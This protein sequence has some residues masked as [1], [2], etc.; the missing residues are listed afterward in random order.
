MRFQRIL[1]TLSLILFVGLLLMAS[2]P[3]VSWIPV[4][5]FLRLDP[6][7]AF[8]SMLGAKAL[9]AGFLLAGLLLVAGL[10]LGRIF[11]GHICPMGTC[12]D[13]ADRVLLGL[14]KAYS[15]PGKPKIAAWSVPIKYCILIAL[16]LAAFLGV[17]LLFWFAPI[18]LIT[19]FFGLVLFP[20]TGKLAGLALNEI[21]PAAQALDW[22]ALYYLTFSS[23]RYA[24]QLFLVVFFL[25]IFLTAYIAPR[26]WCRSLC[27][28]G[29]IFALFSRRPLIR[30]RVCDDC[31]QCGLCVKQCPMSAIADEPAVTRF[32]ECTVCLRCRE[33]CPVDAIS[34]AFSEPDAPRRPELSEH[35]EPTLPSR[36]ALLWSAA[37]G[38]TSA[39]LALTEPRSPFHQGKTGDLSAPYLIRPPGALPEPDF[40]S[41]CLRCG[42][43]MKA[44]P[45][46]TIQPIWFEAGLAAVYSPTILPV[47]GAC[48]PLCNVCGRVCPTGALRPLPLQEKQAAKLGTAVIDRFKCL[49]WEHERKCVVCDEVCPYNAVELKQ[50]PDNPAPVPYVLE[51]RC[52]GCGYCEHHC[53]IRQ[54]RAIHVEPTGALRLAQDSYKE[55]GRIQGLSIELKKQDPDAEVPYPAETPDSWSAPGSGD[56]PPG[57]SPAD[58]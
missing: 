10:L 29:A 23:P 2:Y 50:I 22:D 43:C 13:A 24:T 1:Q 52:A 15:A 5:F 32:Q 55:E 51:T 27:P 57:F 56:L 28:A 14:R 4:D 25:G 49:A 34:F 39:L 38:G 26:F 42:E 30:R 3:L 11:C 7:A 40:L 36:R 21:R 58:E 20:L 17:S 19:R 44:C 53:P 41:L 54:E 45:T 8:L 18:P 47:L 12:I 48:E 31:T 46:N 9:V 16:V 35:Q 6:S 33:V 37:A